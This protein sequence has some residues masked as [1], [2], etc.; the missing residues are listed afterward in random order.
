MRTTIRLLWMVCLLTATGG[1]NGVI[2]LPLRTHS[3]ETTET[4]RC[5]AH[6]R[7]DPDP[8][9]PTV[10]TSGVAKP[11]F[12]SPFYLVTDP[13]ALA[14]RFNNRILVRDDLHTAI[15]EKEF[16]QKSM[17][18]YYYLGFRHNFENYYFETRDQ[19]YPK[20][21]RFRVGLAH[22]GQYNPDD[23]DFSHFRIRIRDSNGDDVLGFN[24][25]TH[26]EALYDEGMM[27]ALGWADPYYHQRNYNTRNFMMGAVDA[28]VGVNRP[29][30]TIRRSYRHADGS[31]SAVHERIDG[32]WDAY[33]TV[34]PD[35]ALDDD[36]FYIR[37]GAP[38][39]L[40]DLREVAGAYTAARVPYALTYTNLIETAWLTKKGSDPEPGRRLF[41]L[42]PDQMY[43]FPPEVF[44]RG[45]TLTLEAWGENDQDEAISPISSLTLRTQVLFQADAGVLANNRF[46]YPNTQTSLGLIGYKFYYTW[47]EG[48]A[49]PVQKVIEQYGDNINTNQDF[50]GMVLDM[51][52]MEEE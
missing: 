15:A 29:F 46:D 51:M 36:G 3:L 34:K 16:I 30:S 32:I 7:E 11:R 27:L 17:G 8:S 24:A 47:T 48:N 42:P 20:T 41:A 40:R 33:F 37:R 26:D 45:E 28:Q 23:V 10:F 50:G 13:D 22:G 14:A 25:A 43:D 1:N 2:A 18:T 21:V 19:S 6:L 12:A 31:I 4:I 52:V 9:I 35:D 44:T 49:D 5:P 38:I 39:L